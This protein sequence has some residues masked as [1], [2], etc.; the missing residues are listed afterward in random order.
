MK[1]VLIT[2]I[3]GFAG[4]HL[5]DLCLAKDDV[6]LY[7][8]KRSH[9]SNTKNVLHIEDK[10]EWFTTDLLDAKA[11]LKTIRAIKP[12]IIFHLAAQS[13]VSQSWNH[14]TLFMAGNY[15][16]TVNILEACLECGINPR[17]HLPGSVSDYG[18]VTEEEL[19]LNPDSRLKPVNPYCVSKIAQDFIGYVYFRSYG[20]NVIRTRAFNHEG[21]R[22]DK[23]FGIPSYAYQIAKIEN[24]LQEPVIKVGHIDDLRAFT[25]VKDMVNAYWLAVEHCSVGELYLI[26]SEDEK[27]VHTFREALEMLIGFSNVEGITYKTHPDFVRPTNVP[28]LTCDASKFTKATNWSPKLDFETLLSDTLNYWRAEFKRGAVR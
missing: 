22:R 27:Y 14:P 21:P 1:K 6:R 23:V 3:N 17:I 19:P 20:S 5:A 10:I 28:K 24:G 16:M 13:F 15:N 7:G 11:V 2:G 26:G 12:D 8:V 18:D 4:S 9:L 25:H